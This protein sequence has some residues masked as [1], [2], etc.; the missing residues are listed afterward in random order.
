VDDGAHGC[1]GPVGHAGVGNRGRATALMLLVVALAGC[2]ATSSAQVT[3][4][5]PASSE[6]ASTVLSN[7]RRAALGCVD[8]PGGQ[9]DNVDGWYPEGGGILDLAGD[10]AG[11]SAALDAFAQAATQAVANAAPGFVLGGIVEVRDTG[12]RCATH[13]SAWFDRGEDRIGVRVWR[14]ESAADPWW[15]PHEALPLIGVPGPASVASFVSIDDSTLV[16]RGEHIVVVLAVAPDGTSVLVSAYGA[17]AAAMVSGWPT[18]TPPP[19]SAP[20]LGAAP[21]SSD[22][23]IPIARGVLTFVLDQ[24]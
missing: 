4:S 24:R 12:R 10:V 2:S 18:T 15:V 7:P 9:R 1:R 16:S 19:A 17:G 6:V 13:R 5:E 21:L 8:E 3:R 22:E 20:E 14:V 11:S 23:S